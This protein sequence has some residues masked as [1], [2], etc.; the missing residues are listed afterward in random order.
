MALQAGKVADTLAEPV[1]QVTRRLA[2][3]NPRTE[4][5]PALWAGDYRDEF[6][7]AV[8]TGT[9]ALALWTAGRAEDLAQA[10]TL[11]GRLWD[12]RHAAAA[13]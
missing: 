8:V 5:L 13:A 1:L 12:E 9:A 4:H 10:Q 11:A 6:A 2:D 3:E 7:E